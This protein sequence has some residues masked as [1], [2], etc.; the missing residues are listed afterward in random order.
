MFDNFDWQKEMFLEDMTGLEN[1]FKNLKNK[2][3]Y[4]KIKEKNY[5]RFILISSPPLSLIPLNKN[6]GETND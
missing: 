1:K 6:N 5:V 2:I 4:C 3:W